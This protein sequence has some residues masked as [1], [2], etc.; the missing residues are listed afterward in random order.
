MNFFNECLEKLEIDQLYK[1]AEFV[2]MENFRHHTNNSLPDDYLKEIYSVFREESL[3]FKNS[4]IFVLKDS[5]NFLLGSIR[6]LKWDYKQKLPLQ[7]IFGLIH[8]Q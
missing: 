7:R 3:Y 5:D 2:V 6:V 8:Y 4:E 1:L